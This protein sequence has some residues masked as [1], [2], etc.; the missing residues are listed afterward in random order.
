MTSRTSLQET[1][2]VICALIER[3]MHEIEPVDLSNEFE[4]RNELVACLMSSQVRAE[5]AEQAMQRL[6]G[7]DLLSD[8]R[9]R[10]KDPQFE[11]DVASALSNLRSAQRGKSYRFPALRARQLDKL[12]TVLQNRPLRTR[13]AL[14]GGISAMRAELTGELPGIGPKQASMFMRNVGI[15]YD[16]AILDVHVLAF[17]NRLG[18]LTI[19]TARIGTLRHYEAAE[20]VAKTYAEARGFRTGLLD[21]AIWITMRAERELTR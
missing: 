1:V 19:D 11:Q 17:F 21:W 12:R 20:D 4:L 14:R 7:A 2:E 15:S 18:L 9:W 16:I 3:R 13:T 6:H 5:S 10:S 8:E